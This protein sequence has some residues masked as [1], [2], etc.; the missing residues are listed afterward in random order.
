MPEP[1][2]LSE[3]SIYSDTMD[4][5]EVFNQYVQQYDPEWENLPK[6][7]LDLVVDDFLKNHGRC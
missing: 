4:E 3:T 5:L 1:F 6:E 7:K 2:T